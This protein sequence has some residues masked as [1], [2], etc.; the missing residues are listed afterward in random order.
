MEQELNELL[1]CIDKISVKGYKS[2]FSEVFQKSVSEESQK[3]CEYLGITSERQSILWSILFSMTVQKNSSIDLED[4][5][6]YLNTSMLKILLYQS[7]FDELVK[8]KLLRRKKSSR[9]R[10]N[11]DSLNYMNLFVPNDIIVSLVN[12][13]MTLPKRRKNDLTIYD[14][15]DIFYS[16][17]RERD[18]ELIDYDELCLE[19]DCLMTENKNHP[20]VKQILKYRLPIHE[21]IILLFVCHQFKENNSTVDLGGILKIL[22]SDTQSQLHIRKDFIDGITKL[23]HPDLDLVDLESES[24][25]S[26]KSIQLTPKGRNLFGDDQHLFF[27]QEI[28]KHNDII[29]S[30]SITEQMLFF[31][32]KEQKSI[33]FLTDLLL[34]DNYTS[35]VNRMKDM[36]MKIGFTVLFHGQPGTGKTESVYQISKSTGRDIKRVEPSTTKSK[37]F[38]ESEKLI[39]NVFDS[40]KRLVDQSELT[41]ILMFNEVDGILS[42]RKTMGNSSVDQTE[43][44]IQTILL[45]S[46]EEFQG[47]LFSTTNLP[48]NLDKGFERR[49]LYKIFFDKPTSDTRFLI[50]KS[51]LPVL[52][53]K[54]TQFL[55]ETFE[56]SGGQVD[57]VVKKVVMNQILTGITPDLKEIVGF[58]DEE[59]L[60]K[61]TERN[62]I[63]FRIGSV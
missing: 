23:Q 32:E 6:M 55:S 43:N 59:C 19:I 45:Q 53:D 11:S 42:T 48:K 35:I 21:Q 57:N 36:G 62:R 14:I 29:L 49:F 7:D 13:E 58:C 33:D 37:W 54:Q 2:K 3:V 22:F 63:G 39:K 1:K 12:G 44:T 9:R 34:P 51:K 26:D 27:D 52:N 20:F 47:I 18:D 17:L 5:S 30:T 16:I 61:K 41:P 25:R 31:N 8:R 56:F 60:E 15:L 10:R 38:G 28:T 24:F 46:L 4:F 50:W 40:Y